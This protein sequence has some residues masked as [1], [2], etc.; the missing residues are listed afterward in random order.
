MVLLRDWSCDGPVHIVITHIGA[1]GGCM[2]LA[3]TT[4]L[5]GRA[6]TEEGLGCDAGGIRFPCGPEYE[7]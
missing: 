2:D 4:L 7:M 5:G 1:R 3:E 6:K